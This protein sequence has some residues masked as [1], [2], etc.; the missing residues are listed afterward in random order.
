MSNSL[1]LWTPKEKNKKIHTDAQHIYVLLWDIR[2]DIGNIFLHRTE[3]KKIRKRQY[4][5]ALLR[6]DQKCLK[7]SQLIHACRDTHSLIKTINVLVELILVSEWSDLKS[8]PTE[9]IDKYTQS[10][11]NNNHESL[12]EIWTI[13]GL[14]ILLWMREHVL[15]E[16]LKITSHR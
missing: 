13:S 14:L 8:M 3:S 10:V 2:R 11:I 15:E 1:L 4:D 7:V 6:V 5:R 16:Y 12:S 9:N